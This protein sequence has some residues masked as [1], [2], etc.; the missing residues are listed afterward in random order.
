MA[1]NEKGREPVYILVVESDEGRRHWLE[2]ALS[3][4]GYHIRTVASAKEGLRYL[5][6]IPF[7]VVVLGRHLRGRGLAESLSEIKRLYPDLPVIV[8]QVK[9]PIG[10]EYVTGSP[11]AFHCLVRSL[12]SREVTLRER[13]Q[14]A[15]RGRETHSLG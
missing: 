10:R 15:V 7:D 12:Q 13:V 5:E 11:G 6:R 2:H 1:N 14:E 8:N 3:G 4:G 9:W